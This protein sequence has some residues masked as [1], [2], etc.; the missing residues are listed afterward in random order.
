MIPKDILNSNHFI[1]NV[2]I[3]KKKIYAQVYSQARV[4]VSS[5]FT[6]CF[7]PMTKL[8]GQNLKLRSHWVKSSDKSVSMNGLNL[9]STPEIAKTNSKDI[10]T[11]C[12]KLTL[13]WRRSLSYRNQSID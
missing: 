2:Y 1:P 9:I 10:I 12:Q 13:S 11:L 3:M 7:E 6:T 5:L 8:W 4:V